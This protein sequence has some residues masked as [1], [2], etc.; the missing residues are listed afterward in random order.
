MGNWSIPRGLW[1]ITYNHNKCWSENQEK[2]GS[3]KKGF[4]TKDF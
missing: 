1:D 4:A 3:T 2:Q